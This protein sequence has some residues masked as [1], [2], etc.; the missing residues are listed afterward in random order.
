MAIPLELLILTEGRAPGIGVYGPPGMKKTN[1]IHTLPPPIRCFDIG[2]GGTASIIPWVRRKRDFDQADWT[3]YSDQLRQ[4]AYN[5]LTP[6]IQKTIKIKPAPL[7]DVVHYDNT[8]F[9]AYDAFTADVANLDTKMYNSVALDSLQEFSALTQIKAKGKGSEF[10]LMNE[11]NFAWMGA[12]ERAQ[13]L[14]RK[15][16]NYRDSGIFLYMTSGQDIDKEYVK[17]PLEK[18]KGGPPPEPYSIKGTISL[19][20][21]L[22]GILVHFPDILCHAR[23]MTGRVGWV[24]KPEPIIGGDATWDAKDRFG[25]LDD[26]MNPNIREFC[27]KLYGEEVAVRIY[28][29]SR[30]HS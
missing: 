6:E 26:Y 2:E 22:A 10:L 27:L 28:G 9:E 19:P 30:D 25:R 1:A 8:V 3:E 4:E 5:L 20:G 7:I 11:V 15:L 23:M 17:S 18:G 14:L 29:L 16:R 21:K 13:M 12:Q 24:T